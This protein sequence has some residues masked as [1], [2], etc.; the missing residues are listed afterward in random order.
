MIWHLD[1]VDGRDMTANS[2]TP[3]EWQEASLGGL[4]CVSVETMPAFELLFLDD[5]ATY[6]MGSGPLEPPY[7]VDHGRRII[8]ALLGALVNSFEY[9]PEHVPVLTSEMSTARVAFVQ[10]AHDL[11]A[12][13]KEGLTQL[14]SRLMPAVQGELQDN[15]G[16]PGKQ[17]YGVFYYAMV[18]VASGP[19]SIHDDDVATGVQHIFQAWNEEFDRGFVV[20]WRRSDAGQRETGASDQT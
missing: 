17:T 20:P 5:I 16:A 6:L 15:T 1:T 13:G 7:T 8:S 2:L 11:A 18:A 19:S 9:V 10:G 3:E 14:I 12:L 4:I